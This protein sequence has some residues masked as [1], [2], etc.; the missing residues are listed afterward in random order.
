MDARALRDYVGASGFLLKDARPE[1]QAV[2]DHLTQFLVELG[3][4]CYLVIEIKAVAFKPE[5]LGQLAF[6]MTAVDAQVKH[7]DDGPTLGLLLCKTKNE[8]VAEYAL[9]DYSRPLGI[10]EYRL[11]EKLPE[12]LQ[13]SLPTIEQIEREFSGG[14]E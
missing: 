9:R 7:P 8:V 10:S 14:A 1:E 5:H 6:Y 13:T 4:G 3:A 11:I 2:V 12:P